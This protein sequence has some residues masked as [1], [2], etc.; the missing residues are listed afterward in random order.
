M[1]RED[2]LLIGSTSWTDKTLS[3]SGLFYPA[4]VKSAEARLRYYAGQFPVVEVG[5][6]YYALPSERNAH[7]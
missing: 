7:L 3:D 4:E 6:S 5:S 2:E 1:N